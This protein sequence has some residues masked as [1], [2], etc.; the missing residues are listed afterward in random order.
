MIAEADDDPAPAIALVSVGRAELHRLIWSE[1]MRRTS[2]RLGIR[3]DALRLACRVHAIPSP[4]AGFW[5]RRE[6]GLD[7]PV[8][9]LPPMPAA[10]ET[11]TFADGRLVPPPL[12]SPP[13]RVGAVAAVHPV[14]PTTEHLHAAQVE[15]RRSARRLARAEA[16]ATN[17]HRASE[18]TTARAASAARKLAEEPA[19]R[20]A[21]HASAELARTRAADRLARREAEDLALLALLSSGLD[22]NALMAAMGVSSTT[23]ANR[24][25][26]LE[27]ALRRRMRMSDWAAWSLLAPRAHGR[28]DWRD[29][30]AYSA[31]AVTMARLHDLETWYAAARDVAEAQDEADPTTRRE[32]LD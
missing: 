24:T 8:A 29:A 15:A 5:T 25:R 16:R 32:P 31:S 11:V 10:G 22:R 9:A 26:R 28:P 3:P 27:R 18:R 7:A 21:E 30:V 13:G 6:M 17:A 4:T 23:V 20:A 2:A 12:A 1:S 14:S 19:R